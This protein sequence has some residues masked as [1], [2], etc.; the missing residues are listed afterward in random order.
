MSRVF[1]SFFISALAFAALAAPFLPAQAAPLISN[2]DDV[3]KVINKV[4]AWLFWILMSLAV[5]FI[6]VSAYFFLFSGGDP[7]K[8]EQAKNQ[9]IYSVIAVAVALLARSIIALVSKILS[10][11]P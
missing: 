7:K 9:L 6:I 3:L 10:P 4:Q 8:V 11:N 2:F 5:V 1:L